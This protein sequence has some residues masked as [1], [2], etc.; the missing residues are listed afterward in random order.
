MKYNLSKDV[1]LKIT[2]AKGKSKEDLTNGAYHFLQLHLAG[3]EDD[4]F[5]RGEI[6]VT[7]DLFDLDHN[8]RE[9]VEIKLVTYW[10]SGDK[11][12]ATHCFNFRVFMLN[13]KKDDIEL[14]SW[15]M[16]NM[17]E[18]DIEDLNEGEEV[19]FMNCGVT[20][21]DIKPFKH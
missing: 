18:F 5:T 10:W 6:I 16:A 20:Q 9:Y 17:G 13:H 1:S 11:C 7:F 8:Q 4:L 15:H 14:T 3:S 19:L 2:K 12:T 21:F